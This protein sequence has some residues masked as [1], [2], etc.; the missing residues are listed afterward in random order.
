MAFSNVDLASHPH[1]VAPKIQHACLSTAPPC[2]QSS[3]VHQ[4]RIVPSFNPSPATLTS[5]MQ[6]CTLIIRCIFP[7][8]MASSLQSVVSDVVHS[9]THARAAC[10]QRTPAHHRQPLQRVV[11]HRPPPAQHL[12]R[13]PLNALWPHLS[14]HNKASTLVPLLL[15][16]FLALLLAPWDAS[17]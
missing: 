7:T 11:Q 4:A 9:D 5:L 13:S 2:N 3:V 16:S 12:Y 1:S 17:A 14:N 8:Q 15:A 6:L 10:A